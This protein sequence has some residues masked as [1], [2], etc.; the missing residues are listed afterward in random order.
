MTKRPIE[1]RKAFQARCPSCKKELIISEAQNGQTIQCPHK[2][3][4]KAFT[5]R[6]KLDAGKGNVEFEQEAEELDL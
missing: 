4:D 3:C 6:I 1:T 2:N 5:V